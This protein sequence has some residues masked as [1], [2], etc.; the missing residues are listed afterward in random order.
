MRY[1]R[2]ISPV[3]SPLG[4]RGRW[5]I[6]LLAAALAAVV[7][8]RQRSPVT[9]PPADAAAPGGYVLFAPL[10]STTTYLIDRAGRAVHTWESDCPP[11]ASQYLL[12]NGHL[13]RCG[14]QLD[15]PGFSGGG[16]GG[17]IHEL[18]WDGQVV[19][20]YILASAER[21]QHHDIEPLPNGNVL[22]LAWESKSREEALRAG[23]RPR[24]VGEAGLWPECV[25]EVRPKRPRGGEIVWEWHMWDHLVQ[26]HDPSISNYGTIADHAERIDINGGRAAGSVTEELVERLRTLGYLARGG[27]AP[28]IEADFAHANSVDYNPRLDQIV[29]SVHQYHEVWIIDHATT[30]AEAAGHRGGR[31]GRGGDLLYRWGNLRAYGRGTSAQQL[32][33]AQHDARWIP[34]GFPGAGHLTVFNNGAGRPGGDYSSVLE[35]A[36][37]VD[38][39]GRYALGRAGVWGPE[40]AAWE[41]P[42]AGDP[43]FFAEFISGAHRLVGGNTLICDGPRGLFFEVTPGGAKV[44]EFANP[45][46]GDAP[47]PHGDPPFSVFWAT[48][49]PP[50]HPGLA[51]RHLAP[52]EPQPPRDS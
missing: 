51:G 7:T 34:P 32:L 29:L 17:R 15:A 46:R 23:R 22:L 48:H 19:W 42:P 52:L 21:R 1:C 12:D 33:F 13:L 30:S 49:V 11:G 47:N 2:W 35:L 41:Y 18:D 45:Y 8:C 3:T 44:W 36:L 20:E 16:E 38:Q 50:G 28:D 5:A 6:A 24:L 14:R 40:R 37:P 27:G 9:T 10:P 4:V 43:S 39:S 26:D 25:L 31:R